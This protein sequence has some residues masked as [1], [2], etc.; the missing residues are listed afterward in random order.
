MARTT[1]RTKCCTGKTSRKGAR[2]P[3]KPKALPA[4]NAAQL[5]LSILG[6]NSIMWLA[7]SDA[8][9]VAET[10]EFFARTLREQV[11]TIASTKSAQQKRR[12]EGWRREIERD[13]E[14]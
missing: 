6:S 11:A 2:K 14:G 4:G 5:G 10:L 13:L 7:D 12:R 1:V 3:S 8:V 9:I